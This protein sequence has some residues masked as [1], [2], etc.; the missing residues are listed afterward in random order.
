MT[1]T[2]DTPDAQRKPGRQLKFSDEDL[3]ERLLEAGFQQLRDSGL[4]EG[5][6]AIRLDAAIL[7]ADTP[8]QRSYARFRNQK[9]FRKEV[10][11]YVLN[12][13]P[14]NEGIRIAKENA[15]QLLTAFEEDLAG[16]R[17]RVVAARSEIVRLL[18]SISFEMMNESVDWRIYQAIVASVRTAPHADK[19]LSAAVDNVEARA[20]KEYADFLEEMAP[21]LHLAP[22]GEL[23]WTELAI[24]AIALNNGIVLGPPNLYRRDDIVRSG[25]QQPWTLLGITVE[26][27]LL[28]F[29]TDL[30]MDA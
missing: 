25:S 14:A 10:V 11:L 4:L 21:R 1:D 20:V 30:T 23:T 19:D 7:A 8:R 12:D 6:S 22:K 17:D 18:T 5:L 2:A 16:D 3:E 27:L 26:A 28:N 9:Q 24:S 15:H 13:Q 29:Y